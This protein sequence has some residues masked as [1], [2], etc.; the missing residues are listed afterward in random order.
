MDVV[1]PPYPE[2]REQGALATREY[3]VVFWQHQLPPEGSGIPAEQMGW[4]EHTV[5][6]VKVDDVLEAI[7]WAEDHIDEYTDAA[8]HAECTYV[9][10]AKV[11]GEDWML[12][13]A[14]RDPTVEPGAPAEANLSRDLP[15]PPS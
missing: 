13:I 7:A 10:F 3:R 15:L 8:S 5:D 12:Q 9:L 2:Y 11:P 14:G 6:L 1:P 4:S